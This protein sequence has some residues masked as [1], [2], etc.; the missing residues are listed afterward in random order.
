MTTLQGGE[1]HVTI[2][3]HGV[4]RIGTLGAVLNDVAQHF[5]LT[6]AALLERLFGR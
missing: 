1:H 6:R 2:P 4:L 5:G 3:R